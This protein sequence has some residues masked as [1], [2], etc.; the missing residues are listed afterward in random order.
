[1]HVRQIPV[2]SEQLVQFAG[3]GIQLAKVPLG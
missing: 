1:M 2:L 3:Q